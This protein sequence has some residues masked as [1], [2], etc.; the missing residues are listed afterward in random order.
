MLF[1]SNAWGIL[2]YFDKIE[3]KENGASKT[4]ALLGLY[5]T[6]VKTLSLKGCFGHVFARAGASIVVNLTL[7]NRTV[8]SF[9]VIESAKHT[10]SNNEHSMDLKL[11]GGGFNG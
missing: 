8:K 10:F 2:Q 9:L 5:N 7:R 6:P 1:R 11:I 4:N 3:G